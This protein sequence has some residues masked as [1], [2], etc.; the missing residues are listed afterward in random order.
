MEVVNIVCAGVGGQ[1]ILFAS[2]VISEVAFLEGDDVKA[3]E[4]HGMAQRG[5]SV[6]SQIRFGKKVYSPLIKK[7]TADFLVA[8]EKLE[9]LRFA[10]YL[11]ID[12]IAI[13]NDYEILPPSA[14]SGL[15]EY[16][17]NIE[18]LLAQSFK[19][20]Y[21]IKAAEIASELGDVRTTNTILLGALSTFLQFEEKNWKVV[22]ENVLKEKAID[23]NWNAFL[24]G[25]A[26]LC[27][28]MK[29]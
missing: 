21:L 18:G 26:I 7:G 6:I 11:K 8:L 4:I 19:N 15:S 16:P 28:G 24:K 1:G 10:D 14:S 22:L 13:V 25:R 27:S 17:E 29:K 20:L 23:I 3:N 9:G 2:K 12:G 5:G